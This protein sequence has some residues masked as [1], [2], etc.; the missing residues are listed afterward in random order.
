MLPILGRALGAIARMEPALEIGTAT[1][2]HFGTWAET[3]TGR[4]AF[5]IFD[6]VPA[7]SGMLLVLPLPLVRTLVDRYY[8]G[9]GK[10]NA[11]LMAS[12]TPEF[13]AAE[14]QIAK[15]LA[16][17]IAG[18][19][20]ATWSAFGPVQFSPKAC[21]VNPDDI[22]GYAASD[23]LICAEFSIK[24]SA[25]DPCET[26]HILY[27]ATGIAA[28][29]A[30]PVTETAAQE[31]QAAADDGWHDILAQ[32]IGEVQLPLRTVLARP[33]LSVAQLLALQPGDILPIP[34]PH[35]VPL[36]VDGARF[37]T[38]AIGQSGGQA[39]LRI[40]ALCNGTDQNQF[41]ADFVEI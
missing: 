20:A 27:P 8:G 31:Q 17:E 11:K 6:M 10:S 41:S 13:T 23:P 39:A 22:A 35:S 1:L 28:L 34:M 21:A 2:L 12:A 5:H 14:L 7:K 16:G 32:R 26:I 40:E 9:T 38:G 29:L 25:Y 3:E 4:A 36:L 33:V 19:L 37:A 24:F 30:K 18:G 15:Q